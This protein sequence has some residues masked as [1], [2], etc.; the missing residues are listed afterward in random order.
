[1]TEN[2]LDVL[3]GCKSPAAYVL[4]AA[5]ERLAILRG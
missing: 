4:G 2:P 5:F 3:F 1:M